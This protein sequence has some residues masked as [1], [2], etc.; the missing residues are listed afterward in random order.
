[1]AIVDESNRR[2]D[3]LQSQGNN[4]ARGL[5]TRARVKSATNKTRFARTDLC[6]QYTLTF[7]V[8]PSRTNSKQYNSPAEGDGHQNH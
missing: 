8:K 3:S 6:A 5:H 1:M 7:Q 4:A 2:N